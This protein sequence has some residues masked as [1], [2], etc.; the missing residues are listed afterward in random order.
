MLEELLLDIPVSNRG[1]AYLI[2]GDPV[3]FARSA[4]VLRRHEVPV[5]GFVFDAWF[6]GREPPWGVRKEV[7]IGH[8]VRIYTPKR[9]YVR[10]LPDDASAKT[11]W[12]SS[13]GVSMR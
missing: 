3:L 11:S 2:G 5:R 12:R 10:R 7:L 6:S 13:V 1:Y 8:D 4:G 9:T